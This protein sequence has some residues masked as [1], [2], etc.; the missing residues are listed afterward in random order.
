[1]QVLFVSDLVLDEQP[2]PQELLNEGLAVDYVV[3]K[4]LRLEL[5]GRTVESALV[6]GKVPACDEE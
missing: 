6:I 5:L 2:L 3:W 1:M 4:G